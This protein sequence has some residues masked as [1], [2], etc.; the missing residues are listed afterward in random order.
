M[1][2]AAVLGAR[3]KYVVWPFR[4]L[5]WTRQVLQTLVPSAELVVADDLNAGKQYNERALAA[6]NSS[7]C[8]AVEHFY[9]VLDGHPFFRGRAAAAAVREAAYRSCGLRPRVRHEPASKLRVVLIDRNKTSGEASRR[10]FA[11]LSEV[12][13]AVR[14]CPA[15]ASL[16]V[17]TPSAALSLCEQI[18]LYAEGL[19]AMLS[20]HGA[21]NT[22]GIFLPPGA[23]LLEGMPWANVGVGYWGLMKWSAVAHHIAYSARPPPSDYVF[24]DG[25]LDDWQCGRQHECRYGYRWNAHL[26]VAPALVC[27]L[28]IAHQRSANRTSPREVLTMPEMWTH[29]WHNPDVPLPDPLV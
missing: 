7:H 3:P 26:H 19:D 23:L 12:K 14:R 6:A 2:E 11:R 13:D 8:D 15:V 20:P 16:E 9:P 17:R 21:H 5:N 22:N 24:G 10:N 1:G 4:L 18:A 29:R 25:S 28:L 27:K